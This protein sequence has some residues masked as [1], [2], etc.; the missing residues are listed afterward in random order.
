MEGGG[1]ICMTWYTI[2]CK[3][4]KARPFYRKERRALLLYCC[5]IMDDKVEQIFPSKKSRWLFGEEAG[6][7]EGHGDEADA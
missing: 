2:N 3:H 1:N 4:E 6:G 7:C 5:K